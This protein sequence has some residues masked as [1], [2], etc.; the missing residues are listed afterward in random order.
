MIPFDTIARGY[1]IGTN[2]LQRVRQGVM[3]Y[4]PR[5]RYVGRSIDLYGEYS[6]EEAVLFK[7]LLREGAVVLD[8][9]AHIGPHTLVLAGTVGRR[10]AVLAFEP[11]RVLFQMLC[12]NTA[13]NNHTH[14]YCYHA[15]VGSH[16][17]SLFVPE[18]DYTAENNFAGLSL[19]GH[20]QGEKVSLMT[21]DDLALQ[22][23]DFMKIDVEGME[24]DVLQGA[25]K[26]IERFKPV[27][28]VEDDRKEKSADLVACLESLGY[29]IYRHRPPLFNPD[30]FKACAENVFKGIVSMN[31]LCFHNRLQAKVDGLERVL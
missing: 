2:Q 6:N 13:L 30:N 7:S 22:R 19:G 24:L 25:E 11:Q 9:G 26:T 1:P 17:G 20:R 10:G 29:D 3:L 28:Y 21:V 12:A 14:V 8:I 23:C 27:L 15:A 5:D 31:L 16:N 18:L 4:N